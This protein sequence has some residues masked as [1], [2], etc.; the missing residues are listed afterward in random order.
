MNEG[1]SLLTGKAVKLVKK[2]LKVQNLQLLQ[3]L[4][5]RFCPLDL[6]LDIPGPLNQI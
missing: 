1:H 2:R 4:L 3:S 5:R 6:M